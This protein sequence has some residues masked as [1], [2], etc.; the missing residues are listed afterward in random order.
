MKWKKDEP[1]E[2]VRGHQNNGKRK[3]Y[4]EQDCG[5]ETLCHSWRGQASQRY[6]SIKVQ[7]KPVKVHQWA[8]E[9]ACGP[10]PDGMV[11]H[12]RCENTRCCNVE[13]LEVVTTAQNSHFGSSAKLSTD[14][15][16]QIRRFYGSGGYTLRKLAEMYGVSR[17]SIQNVVYGHTWKPV[18]MH[19]P[20][21]PPRR[22]DN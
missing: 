3:G 4:D 12:H 8:W 16:E 14:K 18:E 20:L 13:H 19:R 10:V 21:G 6:P 7:G 2:Y 5:Y 9:Q 15:A 1:L 11:V 17:A 22:K